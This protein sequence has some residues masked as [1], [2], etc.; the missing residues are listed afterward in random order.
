M[1]C[2][3]LL[4]KYYPMILYSV[5]SI[6]AIFHKK[7]IGFTF[8]L[9]SIKDGLIQIASQTQVNKPLSSTGHPPSNDD[10]SDSQKIQQFT[11]IRARAWAYERKFRSSG[12][13]A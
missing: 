9:Q 11:S 4:R 8:T 1:L 2:I 3:F 7:C 12:K 13:L 6:C 10:L 5:I